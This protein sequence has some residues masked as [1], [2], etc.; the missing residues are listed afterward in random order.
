MAKR[1]KQATPSVGE[2]SPAQLDDLWKDAAMSREFAR[3]HV[4]DALSGDEPRGAQ[5]YLQWFVRQNET[6]GGTGIGEA[7]EYVH[8]AI[9]RYLKARG[10]M[11]LGAAFGLERPGK[12]GP[13]PMRIGQF[14]AIVDVIEYVHLKCGL[15]T[16]EP[17]TAKPETAFDLASTLIKRYWQNECKAY[18]A[19]TLRTEFWLKRKSRMGDKG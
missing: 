13:A 19:S 16:T 10:S 8:K 11:T 4:A 5:I 7:N 15:P 1:H 12:T 17:G 2:L 6:A 14:A 18:K 3:D 9:V